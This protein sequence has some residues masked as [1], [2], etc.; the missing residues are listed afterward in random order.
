[1]RA[2]HDGRFKLL[3]TVPPHTQNALAKSRDRLGN[4][5]KKNVDLFVPKVST[6]AVACPFTR[7]VA[8]TLR[9]PLAIATAKEKAGGVVIR[10]AQGS[11]VGVDYRAPEKLEARV[12]TLT[13]SSPLGEA[14]CT[15]PLVPGP[16][17]RA[18]AHFD[19]PFLLADGTSRTK[20]TLVALDRFGNEQ[21]E[22][23]ARLYEGAAQLGSDV[24]SVLGSE[25][26]ELRIE[27]KQLGLPDI[28]EAVSLFQI[29]DRG[30][31]LLAGSTPLCV[32]LVPLDA[33]ETL[34][35][36]DEAGEALVPVKRGKELCVDRAQGS[37]LFSHAG[38]GQ[39]LLAPGVNK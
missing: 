29:P 37:V 9:L 36:V 2:A 4:T 5:T 25:R 21:S 11:V 10:A 17:V 39:S 14:T 18:E 15:F 38:S 27:V 20:V 1:V 32:T 7:V 3:V 33:A 16:A 28:R 6:L 31:R 12:E 19:P 30:V 35:A 34:T 26:R 24:A 23:D 8:G 22:V 13:F